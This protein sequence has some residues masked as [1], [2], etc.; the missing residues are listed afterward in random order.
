MALASTPDLSSYG[1]G[2]RWAQQ[3][4]ITGPSQGTY[5]NSSY[6]PSSIRTGNTT[7]EGN[8]STALGA[9]II[10]GKNTWK[11]YPAYLNGYGSSI[12][13]GSSM[14]GLELKNKNIY[15]YNTLGVALGSLPGASESIQKELFNLYTLQSPSVNSDTTSNT[16]T[17]SNFLNN[18]FPAS[19]PQGEQGMQGPYQGQPAELSFLHLENKLE[20]R[21]RIR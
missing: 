3:A 14:G 15:F 16:L 8:S 13:G 17:L 7:P 10:K 20:V 18:N 21:S 1:F 19:F 11:E 12:D 2:F 6:Q 9:F 4:Y 5:S